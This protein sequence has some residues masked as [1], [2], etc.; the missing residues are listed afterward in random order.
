[1]FGGSD[2]FGKERMRAASKIA[3][4]RINRYLNKAE[5]LKAN[6]VEANRTTRNVSNSNSYF[7]L[8]SKIKR[9]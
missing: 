6:I 2:K 4:P 7:W 9:G 1:M 8:A 3:V 5:V